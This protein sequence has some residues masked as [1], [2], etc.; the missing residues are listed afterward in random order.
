MNIIRTNFLNSLLLLFIISIL[1]AYNYTVPVLFIK[2]IYMSI[3][4]VF[5]VFFL[6]FLFEIKYLKNKI[7]SIRNNNI[8]KKNSFFLLSVIYILLFVISDIENLFEFSFSLTAFFLILWIKIIIW[9]KKLI[10]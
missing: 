3:L 2:I 9:N 8:N 1:L 6:Y 10:K 4:A 7:S 5:Q